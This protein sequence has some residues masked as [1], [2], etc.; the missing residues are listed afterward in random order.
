MYA[1]KQ[2]MQLEVDEGD[3]LNIEFTSSDPAILNK[4]FQINL[5]DIDEELFGIPDSEYDVSLQIGSAQFGE[6]ITQL[7][8]LMTHLISIVKKIKFYCI[9]NQMI[10]ET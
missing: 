3:K 7:K 1:I 9:Q 8:Y 2:K 6:I 5:I 4:Y 10:V